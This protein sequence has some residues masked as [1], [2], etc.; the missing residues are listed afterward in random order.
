MLQRR[1]S[2]FLRWATVLA[3]C[4]VLLSPGAFRAA[5]QSSGYRVIRTMPLGGQGDW[6]F[7]TVDSD[8]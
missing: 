3:I 2:G 1:F 5:P 6:D 7:V 8:A 4:I